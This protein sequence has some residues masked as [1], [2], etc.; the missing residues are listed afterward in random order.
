MILKN[1]F[2][3]LNTEDFKIVEFLANFFTEICMKENPDVDTY[4]CK[5][6]DWPK[7]RSFLNSLIFGNPFFFA[8][9]SEY[10][11]I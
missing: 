3:Y 2:Y 10:F 1:Q 6:A 11:S 7:I 5:K 9:V 4:W 8:T